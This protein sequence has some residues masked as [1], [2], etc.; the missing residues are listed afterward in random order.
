MVALW[1]ERRI[2]PHLA[3]LLTA[4]LAMVQTPDPEGFI[5]VLRRRNLPLRSLLPRPALARDPLA[6]GDAFWLA[7]AF[8]VHAH[9]ARR[10][11]L[12]S[13]PPATVLEYL[14]PALGPARLAAAEAAAAEAI[15]RLDQALDGPPP[16]APALTQEAL[17]NRLETAIQTGEPLNIRYWSAW[18]G[19]VTQRPVQPQS[20]T[21]QGDRLYLIAHC[22]LR[23]AQRTFR[24]DRILDV[25]R[26]ETAPDASPVPDPRP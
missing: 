1:R 7:V 14:I 26:C 13:V 19:E 22:Y 20:I 11:S 24:L 18:Q 5:Q 12:S 6:P 10:L 16:L 17:L 21:W 15:A 25:T 8:L 23:G 3:R 9:L 4:K 2:R